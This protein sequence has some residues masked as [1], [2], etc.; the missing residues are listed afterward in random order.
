MLE[1]CKQYE[2]EIVIGTDAHVDV[3]IAEY[4]YV[5]ELLSETEFP[6]NLIVNKTLEMFKSKLKKYNHKNAG[7]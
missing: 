7:R 6:E 2:A 5:D 1:Y 4:P 3:D